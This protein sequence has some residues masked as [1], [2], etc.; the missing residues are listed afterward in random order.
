MTIFSQNKTTTCQRKDWRMPY[1]YISHTG[2]TSGLPWERQ[3]LY[4]RLCVWHWLPARTDLHSLHRET[5][6]RL[7]WRIQCYSVCLWTSKYPLIVVE[8]SLFGSVS[9]AA[10]SFLFFGMMLL[11][12][13]TLFSSVAFFRLELVKRTPWEQDLMLTSSRR[14]R[15]L[16]L[17]RLNTFSRALKKKNTPQWKMG[18]LLQILKWMHNS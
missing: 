14:S 16:F 7:F 9:S 15:V 5:N 6:W 8:L 13:S 10:L 18:F 12:A 4:F 17:V 2:R 3:S 1:L 11:R